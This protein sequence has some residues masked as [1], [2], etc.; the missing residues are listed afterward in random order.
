[1]ATARKK[2]AEAMASTD[3]VLEVLDARLPGASSNP[4]IA[5]MRAERQRPVLKILN[6][7]DIADPA[8]TAAWVK[9][10]ASE[11]KP[12]KQGGKQIGRAHV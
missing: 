12:E 8:V 7:A 11:A 2:A 1:M 3:I 6:K 9:A 4:M 10:F 5:T